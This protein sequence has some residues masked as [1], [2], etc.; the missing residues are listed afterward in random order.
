MLS[1]LFHEDCT[2]LMLLLFQ[3]S[4]SPNCL[5]IK[6]RRILYF[7]LTSKYNFWILQY[8]CPE[9]DSLSKRTIWK[10]CISFWQP[11]QL[12]FDTWKW[13]GVTQGPCVAG[14]V[15]VPPKIIQYYLLGMTVVLAWPYRIIQCKSMGV[16]AI[17]AA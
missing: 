12:L 14:R 11:T 16:E 10:N 2:F 1:Q 3:Y 17:R 7:I 8:F 6:I 5:N 13:R 15:G 9:S 4:S